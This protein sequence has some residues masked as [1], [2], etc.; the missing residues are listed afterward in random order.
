MIAQACDETSV[1]SGHV[2]GVQTR[3]R[4]KYPEAIYSHCLAHKLNLVLVSARKNVQ[5]AKNSLNILEALCVHSSRSSSNI[6][7]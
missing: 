1:M 6:H 5:G 3:V 4:E 7:F 2:S